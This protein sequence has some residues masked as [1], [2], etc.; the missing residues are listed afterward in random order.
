M[1]PVNALF[2]AGVCGLLAGVTGRLR[3]GAVRIAIGAGVGVIASALLPVLR[4]FL[5]L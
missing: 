5:G 3:S 2:Y 4:G 1:D